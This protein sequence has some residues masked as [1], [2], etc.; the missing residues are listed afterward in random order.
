M[1][2]PTKFSTKASKIC[3]KLEQSNGYTSAI[4]NWEVGIKIKKGKLD[5]GIS[6]K[7]FANRLK[8]YRSLKIV[9]VDASIWIKDLELKWNHPDPAVRTIATTALTFNALIL[10]KNQIIYR[11]RGVKTTW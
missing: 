8:R 7:D 5:I 10:T 11:F 1:L 3:A 2:G 9:P 6:I 4:S